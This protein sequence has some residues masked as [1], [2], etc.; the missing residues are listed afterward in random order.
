MLGTPVVGR[1][2][3]VASDE[4]GVLATYLAIGT[5]CYMPLF[6]DRATAVDEM[7]RGDVTWGEKTWVEHNA[8]V[9][10]RPGD[11]YSVYGMWN[12]EKK[13]VCWYVNLQDPM[14]PTAIGYDSRDHFLDLVVGEDLASWMWKDE[15]ELASGVAMGFFTSEDAAQFKRNGEAVIELVKN[16]QA[17]WSD[18][19]DFE[20]D[21]S[22]PIPELPAGWDKL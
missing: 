12:E 20:P 15:D 4:G 8:I 5:R 21:P 11:P 7:S 18:W 2:M 17:W 19:R 6:A 3:T 1:P 22:W 16:G 9:L 13:F 10:V 14:V